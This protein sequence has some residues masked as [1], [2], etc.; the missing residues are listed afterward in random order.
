M[1]DEPATRRE[2]LELMRDMLTRALTHEIGK[3]VATISRELRA[4][5]EEL[6]ALPAAEASAPADQIAAAREKRRKAAG[7]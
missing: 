3:D 1:P 4:V 5:W 7:G 2:A 6:E